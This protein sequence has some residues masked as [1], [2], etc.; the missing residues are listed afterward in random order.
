V[1]ITVRRP[2]AGLPTPYGNGRAGGSFEPARSLSHPVYRRG[3]PRVRPWPFDATVDGMGVMLGNRRKGGGPSLTARKP[4]DQAN[5]SPSDFG[6]NAQ[7]PVFGKSATWRTFHLGMGLA[8]EDEDPAKA[9]GRYRWGINVDCSVANRLAMKGPLITRITPVTRNTQLGVP[10]MFDLGDKLYFLN[11]QYLQR[12]DDDGTVSTVHNFGTNRCA[13]D[14]AVF[15]SNFYPDG[16]PAYAYI[17]VLD[18][19]G[20]Y[21]PSAKPPD[22]DQSGNYH[23]DKMCRFDGT[24]VEQHATMTARAFCIIGRDF[25]RA[26]GRNQVSTV[27]VDSDPWDFA[28]WRAENQYLLGDK[29]NS[30]VSLVCNAVGVLVVLKEDGVYSVDAAGEQIRYYPFMK[31][32]QN[33]G[34]GLNWGVFMNDLYVRYGESLYKIDADFKIEEVG[35]NRVGTVDGPVKGRTTAFAG[36]GNFHAYTGMWDADTD[37]CF[38]MKYGSHQVDE[39]GDPQRVEAWH[40]S[41]SYPLAANRITTLFVTPYRAPTGHNRMY[42]GYR[43][44]SIGFFQLPCVPDPAA[45]DQYRYSQQDSWVVFPNWHGG[46]PSNQKPLRYVAVGGDNFDGGHYATVS[47]RLDPV[48]ADAEFGMPWIALAGHFD[49]LPTER[50]EFP[51]RTQC[52]T[53]ALRLELTNG[54]IEQSPL[55]SSLSLRWRLTTD[56]QQVYDLYILAE[57]GLVTRDGTP[58]RRG[59]KTIRDKVRQLAASGQVFE[60]VLA[61]EDIKLVSI[62]DYGEAISW[63]ERG[64][65]WMSAIKVGVAEDATGTTYGTY[66]R[67]RSMKYGDLRGMKYGDLRRI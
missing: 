21:N 65:R 52:A 49:T 20:H 2:G 11:G 32:G 14:V 25:Y 40:G 17:A 45:C 8:V 54:T 6:E 66:G 58:L 59:A 26:N 22:P 44:G 41:L 36:H 56:L 48:S 53:G 46:F 61:D 5:V 60:V 35:P 16:T 4:E 67:L 63:F 13:V 27:D 18:T 19:T 42:V 62:Y 38:L 28:N 51:E 47:Y 10:K 33:L 9:E 12:V 1:A 57:D 31:F 64:R 34:S 23:D 50:I 30:I 29:S 43:D 39:I 15:S 24:T 37:T 55:V 7:N 3:R